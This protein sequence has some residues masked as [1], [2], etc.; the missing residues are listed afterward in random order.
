MAGP[1]TIV[2]VWVHNGTGWVR[3]NGGTPEA[4]SGPQVKVG[5]NWTNCVWVHANVSAVW[6]VCWANIN[7]EIA[8]SPQ[9]A[10]WSADDFDISPY[11]LN[12]YVDINPDGGVDRLHNG[13][14]FN[15][16]SAW[17]NYDCGRTIQFHCLEDV[18]YSSAY[19]TSEPAKGVWGDFTATKAFSAFKSGTGFLNWDTGWATY[20][21][22]KVR[23][24]P[25]GSVPR[26]D[27]DITLQA[28]F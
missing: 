6:K 4:F 28:E 18:N 26:G 9:I 16:Y 8:G 5:S 20:Y 12:A 10:T 25:L 14:V 7:G 1:A 11:S 22:D 2:G 27:V 3:A 17:R 24:D 23:A 15:N 19:V 21:R 13:T